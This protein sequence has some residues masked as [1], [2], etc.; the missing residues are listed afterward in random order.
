M[1]KRMERVWQHV[2]N[3]CQKALECG[4]Q[5][6]LDAF[7]V[8]RCL[9]IQRSDA[10]A[11][12]NRL[13]NQGMLIK[14]GK[15][16][17]KYVTSQA[18]QVMI[19]DLKVKERAAIPDKDQGLPGNCKHK[20]TVKTTAFS[21]IVGEKGSLKAQ[22]ELAKAAV[23]YP[24]NGLHTLIIGETGVGKSLLAEAMWRYGVEIGA[25]KNCFHAEVPFV[26]F[27]CAEYADNPQLLL[28]L[29]FGYTKGAF[30]G[31]HEDKE[32]I[33]DRAK[34]GVLFLD[35]IHRLPPAGQELLYMFIDKG[36]YRR[37]GETHDERKARLMLIGATSEDPG[38]SLI[39]SFRR[40]I[41][42]QI[43]LPSLSE[44]PFQERLALIGFF[45]SQEARR[46]GIPIRISGNALRVF[47]SYH[48]PANIGELRNDLQLCC[49]KS[50]LSHL[51][52]SSEELFVDTDVIPQRI[53]SLVK[54]EPA[55][56]AQDADIFSEG[57]LVAPSEKPYAH[58]LVNDYE[59]PVDLYGFVDKKTKYYKASV[60]TQEEIEYRVGEDLERYFNKV[61]KAFRK[62]ERQ[63]PDSII[64][65]AVWKAANTLI[66]L[67]SQKL[68]RQYNQD[69]IVAL[70]LHLQ[71]FV[72]RIAAERNI[73][74][75]YLKQIEKEY[76]AEF[77]VVKENCPILDE[78]L[79]HKITGAEMGFLAMFLADTTQQTAKN[80]I[81]LII[82]AH[83]ASTAA[84]MAEVANKLLGTQHIKAVDVP[85]NK[86]LSDTINEL[87]QM[88]LLANEGKG[89]L[90]L[91][92]M[93]FFVGME[94]EL[95]QTTS[96]PVRII[97]NT[98]MTLVLEAGKRVL[99]SE[100]SLEEITALI[101]KTNQEYQ[102]VLNHSKLGRYP[103]KG[104]ILTVCPTGTGTATKIRNIIL[105]HIPKA[106]TM[107]IIPI[108]SFID[109]E[110]FLKTIRGQLRLV[111]GSI[112]PG[113]TGVPFIGVNEIL[114]EEGLKKVEVLLRNWNIAEIEAAD[115]QTIATRSEALETLGRQ[116]K[117]FVS[118]L[119]TEKVRACCENLIQ[120]IEAGLYQGQIPL[121]LMVRIYLHA[122]C[123]FDRIATGSS[124]VM[125][126]WGE[127]IISERQAE[128]AIL[129][130]IT[131]RAGK[132]LGLDVPL[133][134]IC[135]YLVVLPNSCG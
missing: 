64:N 122:V 61:V 73:N 11:E 66:A 102:E 135:Y 20:E 90:V 3:E 75:P 87:R 79:G 111:I 91:A 45:V 98:T 129:K 10:S 55:G 69:I 5:P 103:G 57:L 94:K 119:P 133:P 47:C 106:R 56:E 40:R 74:N 126:S 110:E 88:I 39:A 24:P 83:G 76:F 85:L 51:S 34:G 84:S 14:Y 123:M 33:V 31:A 89:V 65:P 95:Y 53:Y 37:L 68:G 16:P 93:I 18:Y 121:D 25:F 108:S 13:H 17:V 43:S 131:L 2:E 70:A 32:G 130:E 80:R 96:I 101:I 22:I 60:L 99:T 58:A 52:S 27:N 63:V 124:L 42:V 116:I 23:V 7:S 115:P 30:T 125:P 36:V 9:G 100:E 6:G 109:M 29:L 28:S 118:G 114:T 4:E 41:P 8:A 71:Q 44:R 120:E 67:G 46:L 92:D 104:V 38:S 48:C 105:T 117:S 54:T 26:V 132:K 107:D 77:A 97:P 72:E 134:E 127:K 82:V 59:L 49:A 78:I 19:R 81:G 50:Y 112:N 62:Q 86:N 128:F 113:I 21:N 1:I 35:E 15:K 12:L